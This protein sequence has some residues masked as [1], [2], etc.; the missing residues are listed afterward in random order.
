M[1][2]AATND[3]DLIGRLSNLS[4]LLKSQVEIS[5]DH[6]RQQESVGGQRRLKLHQVEE[7]VKLYVDGAT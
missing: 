3:V 5:S 7:L 2:S 6:S 1:R 4:E